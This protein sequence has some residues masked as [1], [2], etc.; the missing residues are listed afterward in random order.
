VVTRS[1]V[2]LSFG[3]RLELDVVAG[4]RVP[5]A[6]DLLI[7]AQDVNLVLG[8]VGTL[9]DTGETAQEVLALERFRQSAR[10][11]S[12]LVAPT[13]QGAP[14]V[15]QAV[16]YDFAVTPPVDS[17]VVFETLVSCFEEARK[18]R[19]ARLALAPIG[20]AHGGIEAGRFLSLLT[21]I[22][23]S[24]VELGTSLKQVHLLVRSSEEI[25][26]YE[27]LI[28]GIGAPRRAAGRA[29]A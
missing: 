20:T 18:R 16:V 15:L 4:E 24:A 12:I 19:L 7:V 27:A 28:R 11:G 23:Y 6:T 13:Q 8:E 21:Q 10:P 25:A 9:E 14:L 5:A 17:R 2:V 3:G 1:R 26:T 29:G 22:C